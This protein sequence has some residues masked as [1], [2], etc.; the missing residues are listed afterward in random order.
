MD[1]ALNKIR[2]HP[3]QPSSVPVSRDRPARAFLRAAV[4]GRATSDR[5]LGKPLA[6]RPEGGRPYGAKAAIERPRRRGPQVG[7]ADA[8][9]FTADTALDE[10]GARQ[11]VPGAAAG[12]HNVNQAAHLAGGKRDRGLRE[13]TGISGVDLLVGDHSELLPTTSSLNHPLREASALDRRPA[14]SINRCSPD[15]ERLWKDHEH[16]VL[17]VKLRPPVCTERP[18]L[19]R[20]DVR[21]AERAVENEIGREVDKARTLPKAGRARSSRP[22]GIYLLGDYRFALRSV[23]RVVGGAGEDVLGLVLLAGSFDAVSIGDG[24]LLASKANG[25][26]KQAQKLRPDLPSRS[27]HERFHCRGRYQLSNSADAAT[28]IKYSLYSCTYMPTSS[29][30]LCAGLCLRPVAS[31]RRT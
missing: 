6:P 18:R 2:T 31:R 19:I 8:L 30:I 5:P 4:P 15:H 29:A 13:V 28:V 7:C 12:G 9:H 23:D 3:P 17:A 27:K 14:I 22:G 1:G 21:T 20:L 26:W 25:V 24:K 16:S 11:L 10:G